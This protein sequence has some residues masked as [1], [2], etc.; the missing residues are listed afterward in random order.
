MLK[1]NINNILND[2]SYHKR[3]KQT[4][5]IHYIKKRLNTSL[6]SYDSDVMG[7][8]RSLIKQDARKTLAIIARDSK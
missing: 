4:L 8:Y 3:D 5:L 1:Q 6:A 2:L 7:N